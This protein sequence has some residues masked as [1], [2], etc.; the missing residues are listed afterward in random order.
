MKM[1]SFRESWPAERLRKAK[2]PR[3]DIG[4]YR[5]AQTERSRDPHAR[6]HADRGDM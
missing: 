3:H 5:A 1:F 6:T 4:V 2:H